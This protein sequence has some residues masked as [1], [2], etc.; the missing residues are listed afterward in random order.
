[1]TQAAPEA[2]VYDM[3]GREVRRLGLP[4]AVFGLEPNRAVM[5]Q[6]LVRQLAN[7]RR[8]T[9]STQRRGEVQ[10]TGKKWYRQKGTGR[11]RHGD[12][13]ANLFVGGA[14]AHGPRVRSYR[15]SMPRQMRRL[16]L[17]SA[18]SAKAAE[19]AIVLIEALELEAPRTRLMRELVE[20]TCGQASALV[21]LAGPNEAVER[22]IRNLPRVRYLRAGYLNVRDL[23]G[24]ER[25]VL[26][27]D[28]LEAIVSHLGPGGAA[29]AVEGDQ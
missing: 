26:P 17:R 7:A 24:H 13:T 28:A 8:G 1:M 12:R 3:A 16:A 20:R 22:S 6:A 2:P 15:Q 23:L 11:A 5:H 25:L 29:E 19:D 14:V 10:R 18:L 4:E 21:V 9:H 27:L